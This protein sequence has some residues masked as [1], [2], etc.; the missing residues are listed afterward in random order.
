MLKRTP[1]SCRLPLTLL[2]CAAWFA[3]ARLAYCAEGTA[4][5]SSAAVLPPAAEFAGYGQST[6]TEQGTDGFH[7]P[8]SGA[9]SL[10]PHIARETF[11][12]TLFLGAHPWVGGEIWLNPEIE[13]GF[14][15]DDTL[16]LAGFSSGEAYKVGRA[17]PYFRLQRAFV[18]QSFNVGGASSVAQAGA[19][20]FSIA[21][22]TN[23]VVV[24]VG[25]L[26]VVD[27][28][29]VNR[30]AHDAR[31]DFLNWSLI[32]AGSFDY[33][34]D[35]WGYTVGGAAEW[36]V[37]DWA[38]RGGFFD[39]S[40]VPNSASLDAGFHQWQVD[41]ELEHRHTLF[42]RGGKLDITT[43]ESRG[44]MALLED[45][46]SFARISGRPVQP[47]SVRRYRKRD[48]VSLNLEQQLAGDLGM[49]MRLGSAAGN[50]E[51]FDF[52][53]I[54]RTASAGISLGGQRWHRPG[55]TVALGGVDNAISSQRREFLAAGGLGILLGDGRLAHP[56]NEQIAEAYYQ[57]AISPAL[58]A[59]ADLQWVQN[60]AYNTDRGPVVLYAVRL[61]LTW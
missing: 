28:F 2:V 25:K 10:T 3:H 19:N 1:S 39:L 17:T 15:L 59:T 51:T 29:D 57:A 30:Y 60:P 54:D 47:T 22:S 6:L 33:A 4:A 42:G 53:D 50:V 46:V 24:T 44:D 40:R 5:D 36:Y 16:G 32:D 38:L 23:R 45:A 9:N 49:F 56:G 52:T 34:A 48:G 26:S 12:L 43:F 61:H 35:A 18:R 58:S 13:Q 41:G 55:D 27:I 37:G 20:Q 14:G 7:A 8:Y 11:D 31:A 21:S